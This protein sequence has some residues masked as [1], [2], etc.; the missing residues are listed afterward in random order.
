MQTSTGDETK[1]SVPCVLA[2]VKIVCQNTNG[3]LFI[4]CLYIAFFQSFALPHF[5]YKTSTGYHLTVLFIEVLEWGKGL[6]SFQLH[7]S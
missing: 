6:L 3:I 1:Q 4:L 7:C 5:L 2:D